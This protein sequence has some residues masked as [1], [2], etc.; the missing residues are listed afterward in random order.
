[1]LSTQELF[2][3]SYDATQ[4]S[5]YNKRFPISMTLLPSRKLFA[6]DAVLISAEIAHIWRGS[7]VAMPGKMMNRANPIKVR[8]I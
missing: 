2:L 1:M 3:F 5:H 7:Q 8:I 4:G 6:D